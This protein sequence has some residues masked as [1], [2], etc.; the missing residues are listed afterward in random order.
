LEASRL[1]VQQVGPDF[2]QV[3]REFLLGG[4]GLGLSPGLP[5]PSL[6]AGELL[7]L[8]RGSRAAG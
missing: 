8:R 4:P 3:S 6:R 7:G 1:S 2:P 5:I